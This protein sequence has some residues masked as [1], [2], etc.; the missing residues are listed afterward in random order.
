MIRQLLRAGIPTLSRLRC[1]LEPLKTQFDQL[2]CSS[3]QASS[4]L[5]DA[6]CGNVCRV[7]AQGKCKL[8]IGIDEEYPSSTT[9]GLDV[10]V[11]GDLAHLP[12]KK[13]S[14]DP[15]SVKG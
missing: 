2:A 4:I 10:R 1:S 11:I 8:V 7:S 12:F 15:E 5:L 13:D 9:K 3:L 14:F 6:G